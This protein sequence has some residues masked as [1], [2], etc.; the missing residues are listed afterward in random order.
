MTKE[1]AF[2]KI[3]LILL[4]EKRLPAILMIINTNDYCDNFVVLLWNRVSLSEI[5]YI[6]H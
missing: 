6:I 4:W 5:V 1:N 2:K 3:C